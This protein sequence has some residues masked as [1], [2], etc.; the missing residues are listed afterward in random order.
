MKTEILLGKE[1]YLILKELKEGYSLPEKDIKELL[2]L[3]KN[4]SANKEKKDLNIIKKELNDENINNDVHENKRGNLSDYLVNNV[5]K[6]LS[7]T[8]SFN[9]LF[10]EDD[11]NYYNI[12]MKLNLAERKFLIKFLSSN[13]KW[14]NIEKLIS[15]GENDSNNNIIEN[16][17]KISISSLLAKK[18]ISNFNEII[19]DINK[20]NYNKLFEYLNYLH[21]NNLGE[22]NNKLNNICNK[23]NLKKTV[24]KEI[25]QII[26]QNVL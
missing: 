20:L 17:D 9:N 12:F 22:I 6:I 2:Y 14:Q 10:T 26:S 18:I 25:Y 1:K 4:K 21:V 16:L 23:V 8:S 24:T 3:I 5:G 7:L 15:E 13:K 11:K 19:G